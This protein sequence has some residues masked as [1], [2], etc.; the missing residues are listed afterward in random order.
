M[1]NSQ[2]S[3][4]NK[5]HVQRS[6]NSYLY[7]KGP[8]MQRQTFIT[9][10]LLALIA[11][12]GKPSFASS[13]E[14]NIVDSAT[15]R[16]LANVTVNVESLNA[17]C[18]TNENGVF[19]FESLSAGLHSLKA[20]L[21]G[22]QEA[23][24]HNLQVRP[25]ETKRL[26]IEMTQTVIEMEEVLVTAT[27][28]RSLLSRVPVSASVIS[29]ADLQNR[30]PLTLGD[31][32]QE[33]GGSF[34]KSYG[35]IGGIEGISLRGSS[36]EQVLVLWDGQRLN[37]PLNG[38]IDLSTLSL[39]S[40]E[41]I[42][43]VQGAYSS[44]Y[45]ADAMAGVVNLITRKPALGGKLAGSAHTVFGSYGF[46]RQELDLSQRLGSWSYLLSAN[47]TKS[48]GNF[49][50]T[51]KAVI[52][53]RPKE[54]RRQNSNYASKA[55]F[56]KVAW[57]LGASTRTELQSEYSELDR[58]APGSLIYPTTEG[59]QNDRNT[60][61]HFDLKSTPIS[62]LTLQASSHY[63]ANRIHYGDKNP[64]FPTDSQNDVDSYGANVQGNLKIASQ[65][66]MAGASSLRESA[67]GS[68]VGV[69]KR[70]SLAAFL[71][72]EFQW[73]SLPPMDE[74]QVTLMPS[75]RFDDFSDFGQ[76]TNPTIGIL[77]AKNGEIPFGL[78]ANWGRSFRAP[79]MNDLYWPEN[80]FTAGNP[81][82]KPET[83]RSY[84][85]GL[86]SGI[87]GLKGMEIDVCYFGKNIEDLIQWSAN[88]S[89]GQW[90]PDNISSARIKGTE[91]SISSRDLINN[92]SAELHYTWLDAKNQSGVS[93]FR[94]KQLPYRPEHTASG[95]GTFQLGKSTI[96]VT[97]SYIG[98]CFVD[99]VNQ[100]TL[101]PY[102]LV[103][104]DVSFWPSIGGVKFDLALSVKNL[105]DKAYVV[106]K[107]YPMPGR[108][109][110]VQM[111]IG[112]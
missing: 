42:E 28:E 63:H 23:H 20:Q 9:T 67:H 69:R 39:Q 46:Q 16:P 91:V 90:K 10:A 1:F 99:E 13:I 32:L 6:Q 95:I 76:V 53:A 51:D 74:L 22:Y 83:A 100:E 81:Q 107:D 94:T 62:Y 70:K 36:S 108:L 40:V 78:R 37:S 88:A 29:K 86:R 14:G 97:A 89:T 33:I 7:L 19:S 34:V 54:L 96:T 55:L 104:G 49:E 103:D 87:P 61:V 27:R 48:E 98:R 102:F 59:R 21:I 26:T 44:L 43:I 12:I 72:G 66:L 52:G 106:V 92:L 65:T 111:G 68:D 105:F 109:W 2:L 73:D 75:I 93:A 110:R 56:G 41:K 71:H 85:A 30:N 17:I 5:Q 3:T 60:R 77:I 57:D 79:T 80:P 31:A 64:F 8:T 25:G 112:L 11:L 58:G 15:K 47:S 45:G 50:Y 38:G 35:I 84:E 24:V 82:L 18:I 101:D 4:V